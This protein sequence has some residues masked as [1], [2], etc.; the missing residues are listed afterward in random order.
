MDTT[1]G[2]GGRDA[3]ARL[4]QEHFEDGRVRIV[5]RHLG[6]A[7]S[8]PALRRR[9]RETWGG[10]GRLTFEGFREAY[11]T[12]PVV[13]EAF[14]LSS[15]GSL[16]AAHLFRVFER[17][18]L[19]DRYLEAY[20]RREQEAGGRPIG[21]VIPF[22]GYRGG[23]IIHDG[24]LDVRG[25]R[26]VHDVP[27]DVA[28]HRVTVEPFVRFVRHLAR[29]GWTPGTP[30]RSVL[31]TQG[32]RAPRGYAVRPWMNRA[33]GC[34]PA[35]DVLAFLFSVLR[36]RSGYRRRF[37]RREAGERLVVI[38]YEGLASQTGLSVTQVKRGLEGLR[39][40]GIIASQK[41]LHEGRLVGHIRVDR[42]ALR[43]V[44]G[45]ARRGPGMWSDD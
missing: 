14:A 12:F 3:H 18:S 13:L 45:R 24:D 43:E 10:P 23:V 34:G 33:L 5:L 29:G 30:L 1:F 8:E 4:R 19:L 36:S 44:L 17:T 32:R 16:R 39:E 7:A 11:P 20:T 25:T 6:L 21:L 27:G 2:A 41:R 42:E 9:H 15:V 37:L 22:G 26:L 31:P 40:R 35:K 28:P 38:D